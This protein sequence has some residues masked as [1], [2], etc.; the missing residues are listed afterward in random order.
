MVAPR[1]DETVV[2]KTFPNSFRDTGLLDLLRIEEIESLVICGAMSHMCIDATTRAAFDLGFNC[3]VA[4]DACATKDLNF[5]GKTV[6]ASDVHAAFMAALSVQYAKIVSTRE[7]VENMVQ[8][9]A[10]GQPRTSRATAAFPGLHLRNGGK[11]MSK[12]P[13][14]AGKSSYDLIDTEKTFEMIGV[15]PGSS[16]LD[17]GC[18]AGKYSIRIAKDIGPEGTVYA[19]DLWQEGIDSLRKEADET[20]MRNM[21]T[22]VADICRKL[23]LDEGSIDSCLMA[24]ILHDLSK[25]ARN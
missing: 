12:E 21:R 19:V 18:G 24:T 9:A 6:K 13:V 5:N 1:D 23:P 11:Y 15:K 10:A 16:F 3:T 7:I 22:I 2:V 20:G 4:E 14:A 25:K 8:I 17:L